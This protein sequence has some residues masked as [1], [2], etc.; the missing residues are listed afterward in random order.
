MIQLYLRFLCCTSAFLSLNTL[1][2]FS[3]S[4]SHPLLCFFSGVCFS[5]PLPLQPFCF[6]LSSLLPRMGR[7]L[8]LL[9]CFIVSFPLPLVLIFFIASSWR[10]TICSP[11]VLSMAKPCSLV[12][13]C[14]CS[15]YT[16]GVLLTLHVYSSMRVGCCNFFASQSCGLLQDA[17][18]FSLTGFYSALNVISVSEQLV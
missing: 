5:P 14:F 17:Y 4:C 13:R 7:I 9:H 16:V 15:E 10:F 6:F 1:S 3:H 11:N 2:L 12:F 8:P 18:C